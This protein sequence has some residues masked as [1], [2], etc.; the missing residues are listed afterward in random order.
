LKG[1]AVSWTNFD[2]VETQAVGNESGV[3]ACR[4]IAGNTVVG[5]FD[6][7]ADVF[8]VDEAGQ[9]DWRGQDGRMSI[10]LA[11]TEGKLYAIMPH[12]GIAVS[13]I[14]FINHSC[15]PNCRADAGVLV[16]ETLRPIVRG[17]QLTINYHHMDLVKLGHPCWCADVPDHEKCIL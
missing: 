8:S 7:A 14:D 11:L 3:F 5:V 6:G 9:V 1:F 13:G 4:D 10:H 17:E 2:L 12:P 16:V 15:K